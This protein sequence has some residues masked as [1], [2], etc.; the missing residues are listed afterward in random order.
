[1]ANY[2][3]SAPS[4]TAKNPGNTITSAGINAISDEVTAI[5]SALLTGLAHSLTTNGQVVFPATQSASS[6]A[7][8]LDDYEEGSWTPTL[9]SLGGGAATY[10]AQIGYYVKIGQLVVAN[11]NIEIATAGTLTASAA[12]LSGLPFTV[13]NLHASYA[14][15]GSV[16]FVSLAANLISIVSVAR[17][18]TTYAEL[19]GIGAATA[20][21]AQL[22]STTYIGAGTNLVG[23]IVY[24]ASA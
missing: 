15:I 12:L 20:S 24:R 9:T 23:N 4:F 19:W 13:N 6:G 5:G 22:A 16:L 10:T 8:T 21:L 18:N 7:N 14:P 3:G 11:F 2:P 1:M 17:P